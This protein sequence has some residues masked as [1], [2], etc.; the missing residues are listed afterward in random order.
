VAP[1]SLRRSV[2]L[3]IEDVEETRQGIEQLLAASGYQVSTAK[4]EE[5]S[6][7]KAKLVRPDVIL[8][9]LGLHHDRS[10]AIGKRIRESSALGEDV[11]VVVFCS[12]GLDE[13]AELPAGYKIYVTYPDNFDQLRSLLSR[14]LRK[15]PRSR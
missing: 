13:G 4:D 3:V 14:L 11:P 7:L 6:L 12:S 8:I 15:P 2:I 1:D 9:S 5:E 10:V